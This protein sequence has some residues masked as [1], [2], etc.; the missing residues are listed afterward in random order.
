[1]ERSNSEAVS[2]YIEKLDAPVAAIVEALRR[3]ILSADAE[4]GEEIKWNAPSFFY[5]GEMRPFNPKE[6]KRHII[7]MNLHKR[8]LLVLPSGAKVND[9]SGLLEGSYTDG[10]RLVTIKTMDD[11]TQKE[12]ALRSVIKDW[13]KLVEK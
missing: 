10:R 7:V 2:T 9:T 1:M 11:V 6:Y 4:I 13:L 3:I 12:A 5:T 8:I